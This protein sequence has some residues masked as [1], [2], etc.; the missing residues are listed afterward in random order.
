MDM[1]TLQGVLAEWDRDARVDPCDSTACVVDRSRQELRGEFTTSCGLRRMLGAWNDSVPPVLVRVARF[2]VRGDMRG[3]RDVVERRETVA[4][5]EDI[6][7]SLG[8][9]YSRDV[10]ALGRG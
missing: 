3:T 6:L 4:T 2:T 7:V 8:H 5:G 10:Y 1:D 9:G